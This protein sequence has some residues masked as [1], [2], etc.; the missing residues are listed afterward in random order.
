MVTCTYRYSLLKPSNTLT[1]IS[2][3]SPRYLTFTVGLI[4]LT[5]FCFPLPIYM[6]R[7][8]RSYGYVI[9]LSLGVPSR[10]TWHL[11]GVRM[12]PLGKLESLKVEVDEGED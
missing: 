4:L 12:I 5:L 6:F 1:W 3:G 10:R 2:A 7:R 9:S 11:V 8:T